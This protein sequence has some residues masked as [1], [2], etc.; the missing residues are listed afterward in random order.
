M[1][2]EKERKFSIRELAVQLLLIILFICILFWLFPTK[3]TMKKYVDKKKNDVPVSDAS[4]N[5][6]TDTK[7]PE[8]KNSTTKK[9]EPKKSEN[10]VIY[11][12]VKT[13]SGTYGKYGDWSDWTTTPIAESDT[14]EVQIEVR[15]VQTGTSTELVKT[16]VKTELGVIGTVT[17]NR[18]ISGYDYTKIATNSSIN[19]LVSSDEIKYNFIEA[20]GIYSC[21]NNTSLNLT[22]NSKNELGNKVSDASTIIDNVSNFEIPADCTNAKL[23]YVIY[24]YDVY[25]KTPIYTSVSEEKYGNIKTPSYETVS[26]PVYGDVTY[27]RSRTRK[28]SG[29]VIDT[30]WSTKENDESLINKGYQFTGNVKEN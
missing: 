8:T 30:K 7:K 15:N 27:Y 24:T 14:V 18:V 13:S 26:N 21:D 10:K 17:N 4:T 2:E 1:Y 12:Y 20:K 6:K 11:E 22:I 29:D 5:K 9:Q 19:K 28:Y 16:G 23:V 25:E 3:K